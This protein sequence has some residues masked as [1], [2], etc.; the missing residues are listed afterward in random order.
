[1]NADIQ[2]VH[3]MLHDTG[4]R[5]EGTQRDLLNTCTDTHVLVANEEEIL[6]AITVRFGNWSRGHG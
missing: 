6:M 3:P 1:M 2:S 4:I 5:E